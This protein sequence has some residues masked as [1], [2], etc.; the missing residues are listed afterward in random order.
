MAVIT[1]K[2]MHY[3]LTGGK[4]INLICVHKSLKEVGPKQWP[5]HTALTLSRQGRTYL[6][7][8]IR[9]RNIGLVIY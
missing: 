3:V 9:Q 1:V 6:R 2:W 8:L 7:E 4:E 5:K